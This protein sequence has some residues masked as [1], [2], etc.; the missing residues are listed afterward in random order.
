[1]RNHVGV[2]NTSYVCGPRR[3]HRVLPKFWQLTVIEQISGYSIRSRKE[4]YKS[5]T[6]IRGGSGRWDN[7]T[8][9][10]KSYGRK[11]RLGLQRSGKRPGRV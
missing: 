1:M 9:G 5:N 8:A 2:W 11:I 3:A 10:K 6:E 7:V 4:P